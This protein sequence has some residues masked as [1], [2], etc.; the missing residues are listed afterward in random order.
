M[1]NKD[2]S[3]GANLH[4]YH[5]RKT[6]PLRVGFVL[7]VPQAVPVPVTPRLQPCA[8]RSAGTGWRPRR[9]N[10]PVGCFFVAIQLSRRA[11]G[12]NLNLCHRFESCL[13]RL[14]G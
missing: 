8:A 13:Q 6:H 3:G 4:D 9:K 14:G 10:T 1:K 7:C 12:D 5:K 11:G 2:F